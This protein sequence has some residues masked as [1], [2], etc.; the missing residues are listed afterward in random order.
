MLYKSVEIT[1]VYI[2]IAND[3]KGWKCV[4][5]ITI[6]I[7]YNLIFQFILAA[8]FTNFIIEINMTLAAS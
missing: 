3:L 2:D 5:V 6:I 7:F 1:D 4:L 8:N